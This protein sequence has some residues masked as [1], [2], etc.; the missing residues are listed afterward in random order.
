L[1]NGYELTQALSIS[2]NQ[3]PDIGTYSQLYDR[4]RINMVKIR[5]I[6]VAD[7]AIFP[8]EVALG[9]AL[10]RPNMGRFAYKYD[11]EDNTAPAN[12]TALEAS[13]SAKV[14]QYISKRSLVF[15]LYP[16]VLQL[17]GNP[18]GG[19]TGT[20]V[21][22][23]RVWLPTNQPGVPHYGFKFAIQY[24]TGGAV[25]QPATVAAMR[26]EYQIEYWLSFKT[27]L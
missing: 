3:M 2:A 24:N 25:Y 22:K 1:G 9:V 6:K 10:G 20:S 23:R 5:F 7:T 12:F 8:E 13:T 11:M 19:I 4:Y 16:K 18:A 26:C 27:G 14:L 15:K 17:T 21:S